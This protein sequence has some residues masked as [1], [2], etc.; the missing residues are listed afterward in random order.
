MENLQRKTQP[1]SL[2][3]TDKVGYV[4]KAEDAI[5]GVFLSRSDFTCA[6]KPNSRYKF[7]SLLC[8]TALAS[9]ENVGI[10]DSGPDFRNSFRISESS[11]WII[12]FHE[13]VRKIHWCNMMQPLIP[14]HDESFLETIRLRVWEPRLNVSQIMAS[15]SL[16][17]V[18]NA[19][20]RGFT[21]LGLFSDSWVHRGTH[22]R[23][24]LTTAWQTGGKTC[25]FTKKRISGS[26]ISRTSE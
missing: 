10:A 4:K 2:G 20:N 26:R 5:L 14:R 6:R 7:W 18:K 3:P 24:R 23:W 15:V 13:R 1:I 8:S 11:N 21:K 25:I 19:G 12:R 22:W 17:Y 9:C 16:S